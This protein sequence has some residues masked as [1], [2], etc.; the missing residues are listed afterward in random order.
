[1]NMVVVWKYEDTY[2][3]FIIQIIPLLLFMQ[4]FICVTTVRFCTYFNS[5]LISMNL[6]LLTIIEL[7]TI[8]AAIQ[9]CY[10]ALYNSKFST[11]NYKLHILC[12]TKSHNFFCT[13][14]TLL[15]SKPHLIQIFP[16]IGGRAYFVLESLNA[17][18]F[19]SFI[20]ME[21]CKIY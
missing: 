3:L 1:M 9:D 5:A 12:N 16:P 13:I 21:T 19:K 17:A 7:L 10:R 18:P 6:F 2:S 11:S 20:S 15:Q 14:C 8:A 4:Y